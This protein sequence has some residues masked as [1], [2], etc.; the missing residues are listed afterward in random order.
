MGPISPLRII[1]M[2]SPEFAVP[3]LKKLAESEH[4]IVAVVTGSDKKRGR[5][6]ELSP[7]VVKS[8]ALELGL[9][10]IETDDV[11]SAEFEMAIKQLQP[12]LLVVVAFK[13][14]PPNIL[15]IPKIGS[16]NLHASLLPK[17]RGAAPIHRAV[18]N[19][20]TETGVTIFFLDER[21]DTGSYLLQSKTEISSDETTGEIYNKL[22]YSGSDKLLE[23][24]D[25]I[26]HGDFK[27][28]KQDDTRATKAPKLFQED[29]EIRFDKDAHDV[30]NQIRGLSPF[31]TAFCSMDGKK[32]KVFR[33]Q[34]V[35]FDYVDATVQTGNIYNLDSAFIVACKKG[36]IELLEVQLEGK[37]RMQGASFLRGYIGDKI[38][39]SNYS[40]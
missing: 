31:P 26:A 6:N 10:V 22:M 27:L 37:K 40:G 39:N 8:T 38:I 35:D 20:E 32:L 18:M 25:I 36:A 24:V 29:C 1:F 23:A 28:F 17:Y 21:I 5:G 19:G 4:H 33:S 2:G 14:L 15:R 3:S 11:K 7:T 16:I 13:V 9:N 34:L 12:D 30:H